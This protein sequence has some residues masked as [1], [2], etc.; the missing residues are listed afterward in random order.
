MKERFQNVGEWKKLAARLGQFQQ[1]LKTRVI[2]ILNFTRPHAI[3]YTNF[4]WNLCHMKRSVF[5]KTVVFL[6]VA[7]E[8]NAKFRLKYQ[9][10]IL[11]SNLSSQKD[12]KSCRLNVDHSLRQKCSL[13]KRLQSFALKIVVSKTLD[14]SY[15]TA[16]ISRSHR[17]GWV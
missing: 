4:Q 8:R 1:L 16:D 14:L 3:T 6:C 9:T 7:G 15:V 2:L 13:N 11:R 5:K 12:L 10:D 17:Y